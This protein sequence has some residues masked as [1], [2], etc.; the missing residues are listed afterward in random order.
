MLSESGGPFI[1]VE[2][3]DL[4]KYAQRPELAKVLFDYIL[5][6]D[7]NPRKALELA[8]YATQIANFEDWWWKV[9]QPVG[10]PPPPTLPYFHH[11]SSPLASRPVHT[12]AAAAAAAAV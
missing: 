10:N 9:Q 3:L 1:R 8:N 2:R 5:Y 7:H 6:H 4:K 11:S 12:A